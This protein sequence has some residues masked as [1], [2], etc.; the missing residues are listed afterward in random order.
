MK[1]LNIVQKNASDA[2]LNPAVV[3]TLQNS[4]LVTEWLITIRNA[5]KYLHLNC[6]TFIV[7]NTS[8]LA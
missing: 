6:L 2:E 7:L 8:S 1:P 5:S 4:Q 3:E